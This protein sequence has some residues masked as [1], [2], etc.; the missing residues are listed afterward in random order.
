MLPDERVNDTERLTRTGRTQYNRATER[1]DDIDPSFVHFF[2]PVVYHRNVHRII[3][4]DQ[5]FRLLERF[6]FK[7][8]TVLTNLVV[9]YLAI[10]SSP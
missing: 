9:I 3:V 10:P 6:V 7:V 8:E 5:R 2:L 1:I 4:A